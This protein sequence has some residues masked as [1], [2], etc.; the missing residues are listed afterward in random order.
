MRR[1]K[2]EEQSQKKEEIILASS[3]IIAG[4]GLIASVKVYK[5]KQKRAAMPWSAYAKK[6]AKKKGFLG[7]EKKR[8]LLDILSPTARFQ[9][10]TVIVGGSMRASQ[11]EPI[12]VRDVD[13]LPD[14]FDDATKRSQFLSWLQKREKELRRLLRW[15]FESATRQTQIVLSTL[16]PSSDS[17][18]M[19]DD[20]F[21]A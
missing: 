15:A 20:S 13:E 8:G 11:G 9:A 5:E 19:N 7:R 18:V 1:R 4:G 2:L 10:S 16:K 21:A 6:M 14:W 17:E 3:V 12:L